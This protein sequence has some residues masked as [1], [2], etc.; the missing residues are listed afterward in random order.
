VASSAPQRI[1]TS[2][3]D[4]ARR[5]NILRPG[6]IVLAVSGGTDSTTLALILAELREELGLVLHVAH[7][8]HRTRPR[9]APRE[10]AF[11]ADLANHVG[12]ALRVG[13][14]DAKPKSED[15]ARRARYTFLR[16]VAQDVGATAIATGHTKD[17]QA[18][19][20]LLHLV[21]GSGIDGLAGMRPERDGIVRPLLAITRKDTSAIVRAARI[22][23]LEDPTNRSL[24][25]ARNRVRHKV[26]PELRKL[27]PEAVDAI[28]RLA[29]A[30]SEIAD[31]AHV[32]TETAIANAD[33]GERLDLDRVPAEQRETALAAWWEK[34]TGRRLT[35]RHRKALD[36]LVAD[37]RGSKSIDLPGG[38]ALREYGHLTIADAT[39]S[40][41]DGAITLRKGNTAVWHGWRFSLD[42]ARG[43]PGAEIARVSAEEAGR[44]VVRSRRAGDRVGVRNG[45]KVQDVFTNKKVPVRERDTWP[46]V[47]VMDRVIWIPGLTAPPRDGEVALEVQRNVEDPPKANKW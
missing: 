32:R 31:R 36:A 7:F 29:D 34:R 13:R 26:V 39:P 47:T 2:V 4:F 18:E 24:R 19:T 10:A 28:A 1:I 25:F 40:A 22:K 42:P 14:A 20:V 12:A 3:R 45:A 21:R 5:H 9:A 38:R 33:D 30:A 27:N 15:D 35:A 43:D 46:L 41:S 37:R 23:P 16:R 17:D 6:P 11:V 8:D 44:L